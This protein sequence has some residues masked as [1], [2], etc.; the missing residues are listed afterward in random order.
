MGTSLGE[1]RTKL[2]AQYAHD[3]EQGEQARV[4][5]MLMVVS[6]MSSVLYR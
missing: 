3:S 1:G 6:R 5:S 2:R 4:L